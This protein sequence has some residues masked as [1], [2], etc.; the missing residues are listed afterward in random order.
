MLDKHLSP[1]Y[2]ETTPS[3]EVVRRVFR[4]HEAMDGRVFEVASGFGGEGWSAKGFL[5]L[6][7]DQRRWVGRYE[8]R[9]E[10][11]KKI[12]YLTPDGKVTP[13][14]RRHFSVARGV[15]TPELQRI[16]L[17][18][19]RHAA[20]TSARQG[21]PVAVPSVW[22]ASQRYENVRRRVER[23][24]ISREEL[25][26]I[27]E[28]AERR[29]PTTENLRLIRKQFEREVLASRPKV[30]PPLPATKGIAEAYLGLQKARVRA[31]G[32]MAL[33]LIR[34]QYTRHKKIAAA[35]R[36]GA[37]R[38]LFY[39]KERRLAEVGRMLRPMF[40]ATRVILPRQTRRLELAIAR[41][42]A[43]QKTRKYSREWRRNF[44]ADRKQ[45]LLAE[46]A[47][48]QARA[49][50]STPQPLDSPRSPAPRTQAQPAPGAN[51]AQERRL[52]LLR[53][54]HELLRGHRP[55]LAAVV[56]PWVKDLQ[57]L[58]AR[59]IAVSK[60]RTDQLPAGVYQ[61][62]SLAVRAAGLLEREK[63]AR[64][65]S[66]PTRLAQHE[67][68]IRRVQA[69][70]YAA[71]HGEIFSPEML[72]SLPPRRIEG[73]LEEVR[74]AGLA[75]TC[76]AWALRQ[77]ELNDLTKRLAPALKREMEREQGLG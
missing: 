15:D 45:R 16:R 54:G 32:V 37:S 59:A 43:L 44:V 7:P 10:T 63:D 4:L 40:W 51:P 11:L 8:K 25:R 38:D 35:I 23:L 62:A 17:D 26:H 27:R 58:E 20:R 76:P 24:G 28:E 1:A 3:G 55:D 69:R 36:A 53:A 61:A 65:V 22:E 14:F 70:F 19:A 72:R 39:A 21:R 68:E 41:C 13:T 74:K 47:R 48:G 50:T 30:L 64:P 2:T 67:A 49:A 9:V 52:R 12:G 60:G 75:D 73:V 66:V 33:G 29:K 46:R 5:E 31:I 56:A 77:R 18:L 6:A 34:L 57:D 42:V 71:K